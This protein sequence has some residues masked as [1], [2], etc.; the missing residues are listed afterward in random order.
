M[1][2]PATVPA[3]MPD[4]TARLLHDGLDGIADRLAGIEETLRSEREARERWRDLLAELTSLT[5]AG[6]NSLSDVMAAAESRGYFSAAR[7]GAGAV[8]RFVST[9]DAT[10][11]APA[12]STLA[13][14]RRLRDPQVRR[15]LGRALDLLDALGADN[16]A[17]D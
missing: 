4:E 10:P 11:D 9:L 16:T 2:A 7:Y 8:D 13:L 5:G 3:T 17:K 6:M 1:S 15:G 14:L 12:P